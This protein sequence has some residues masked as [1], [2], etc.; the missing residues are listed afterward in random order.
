LVSRADGLV[1]ADNPAGSIV[2]KS[3][4][5]VKPPNV[6]GNA[7]APTESGRRDFLNTRVQPRPGSRTGVS[8]HRSGHS[9]P[10]A[11]NSQW[12]VRWVK[13]PHT[14][15]YAGDPNYTP[16]W[17]Y[18]TPQ[19]RGPWQQAIDRRPQCLTGDVCMVSFMDGSVRGVSASVNPAN[20]AA[21]CT[22]AGGE[23]IGLD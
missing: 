14:G 12:L 9:N 4:R 23:T 2:A 11:L 6:K 3:G 19:P 16:A 5:F 20:W 10:F 21:V 13:L 1:P 22:P 17:P 7:A 8:G 15:S 18:Y